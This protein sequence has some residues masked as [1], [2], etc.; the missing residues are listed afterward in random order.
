MIKLKNIFKTILL[1]LVVFSMFSCNK[2]DGLDTGQHLE[3]NRI[4]VINYLRSNPSYSIFTK[5]LDITKLSEAL[6]VYGT[7][8]VFAPSD[9][10]FKKYFERKKISDITQVNKDTLLNILKYHIYN[11]QYGSA[12][13]VMGTL[14]TSTIGGNFIKF[15]ISNGLN[16]ARL[17]NTV[18]LDTMDIVGSNGVIHGIN[19]VLEPPTIS[20][21]D[22]VKG[23]SQYSIM[24]EAFE[25]TANADEIL[26]K[27]EFDPTVI[28]YGQPAMKWRTVFLETNEVLKSAGINSFDDLAKKFSNTYA[29]TKD[30]T[31][32]TDSL[33]MFVR[34]HAINQNYF[35][36][37]FTDT[38]KESFSTGNYLVF[39]S[40]NGISINKHVVRTIL[41]ADTTY[42]TFQVNVD[43]KNSNVITKNGFVHSIG[44]V[45]NM[46]PLTPL[47]VIQQ[48]AGAVEDRAIKLLDGTL[49]NI[50]SA[51]N[52]L[53]NNPSGQA[54]VWWL[55]WGYPVGTGSIGARVEWSGDNTTTINNPTQGYWYEITTRLVIA[56]TYNVYI[57]YTGYRRATAAQSSYAQFK[58]D[59]QQLGDVVQLN[60]TDILDAQGAGCVGITPPGGTN[61]YGDNQYRRWVGKVV[62]SSTTSHII[63]I[64]GVGSSSSVISYY[65]VELAP[66]I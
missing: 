66:A 55:K 24:L 33:N 7:M 38:Y 45:M 12:S 27:V 64:D 10:A 31:N 9:S 32:P 46:Y 29:T 14:P 44:S 4:T 37:D 41:G 42:T 43:I 56:G 26:K 1:S 13:F 63:R 18:S 35:I 15:D 8:T 2:G 5:A 57:N 23:Q 28:K 36:S 19:D 62:L 58:F 34:F 49:T 51:F 21:Y 16:Q 60:L 20:L 30:Y 6:G 25:K 65:S 47:S 54:V 39:G 50:G 11:E 61:Y 48:F 52:N 3:K 22:W 40:K 59:N 17:N 53:G